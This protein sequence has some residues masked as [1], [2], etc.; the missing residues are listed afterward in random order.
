MSFNQPL[1]GLVE[2]LPLDF[3]KNQT[4]LHSYVHIGITYILYY[5]IA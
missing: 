3:V 4:H 2:L 5:I 1:C